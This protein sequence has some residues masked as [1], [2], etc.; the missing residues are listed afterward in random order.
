VSSHSVASHV[1]VRALRAC[2]PSLC[3]AQHCV[4]VRCR[5]K[6]Q[7]ARD[8]LYISTRGCNSARRG[9]RRGRPLQCECCVASLP[10]GSA[11][12][13]GDHRRHIRRHQQR[14]EGWGAG[15][16]GAVRWRAECT[17]LSPASYCARC[18]FSSACCFGVSLHARGCC[19]FGSA[20]RRR[21]ALP[22]DALDGPVGAAQQQL[23]DGVGMG[24]GPMQRRAPARTTAAGTRPPHSRQFAAS[25]NGA[26]AVA[27]GVH[28]GAGCD[29]QS[30]NS[31]IAAA[32]R[33]VQR[34]EAI[35][36]AHGGARVRGVGPTGVS[37]SQPVPE[38]K[39]ACR[40][41]GATAFSFRVNVNGKEYSETTTRHPAPRSRIHQ[42]CQTSESRGNGDCGRRR[43][44][45]IGRLGNMAGERT[46]HAT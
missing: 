9:A 30:D 33:Q 20:V 34:G 14:G 45:E 27:L 23:G 16:A 8:V 31:A 38:N 44:R 21:A 22:V 6:Q 5:W 4:R 19:G 11:S 41:R 2:P 12:A 15:W 43:R 40:P 25:G 35:L 39:T 3:A 37:Q 36:A 10:A 26:P 32:R 46:H 28:V 13:D 24:R 7:L 18:P 1:R 42:T 17:W 29:E